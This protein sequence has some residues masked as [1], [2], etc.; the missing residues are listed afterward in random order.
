MEPTSMGRPTPDSGISTPRIPN[1]PV[2]EPEDLLPNNTL[3]LVMAIRGG[4]SSG[5]LNTLQTDRGSGAV[6]GAASIELEST[7]KSVVL[8]LPDSGE[9]T[10]INSYTSPSY[11]PHFKRPYT[12]EDRVYISDKYT[13]GGAMTISEYATEDFSRS[14]EWGPKQ[15]LWIQAMPWQAARSTSRLAALSNGLCREASTQWQA[16]P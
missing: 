8:F 12:V 7:S 10:V 9:T 16:I 15:T 13:D 1:T 3:A 14:A 2:P 4:S 11:A 5:T 6:I